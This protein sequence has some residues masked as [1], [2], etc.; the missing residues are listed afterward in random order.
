MFGNSIAFEDYPIEQV[1]Q[2]MSEVGF[3]GVEPWRPHLRRCRSA[4][5]CASFVE[6]AAGKGVRMG[7]LN[8]VAEPYYKPFGTDRELE[9]T[10]AGLKADVDFAIPLGIRDVLIWEGV[11]PQGASDEY[12]REQL[13]PRL[14]DLFR[15]TLSYA[16]PKG[17]RLRIEPHPFTVAM[18]DQFAVQLCD[19]LDTEHFGITFDFCHY[20]VAKPADYVDSVRVLGHRIRHMHFSDSDR[21]ISELHFTPGRGSVDIPGLLQAFKDIRYTGSA[22]LDLYG[23]PTPIAAARIGIPLLRRACEFLNIDPVPN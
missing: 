13:L 10:L 23:N 7:G 18:N 12:C 6:F 14:V 3:T 8:V 16:V 1:I 11:R 22:T 15:T 2:L 17:I 4:E 9:E 21:C 5:L 20:A 19:A